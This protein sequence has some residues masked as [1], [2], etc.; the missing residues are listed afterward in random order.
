MLNNSWNLPV[1]ANYEF[2]AAACIF[3]KFILYTVELLMN[4][5]I[6]H[7]AH[8]SSISTNNNWMFVKFVNT[9]PPLYLS[10]SKGVVNIP[11]SLMFLPTSS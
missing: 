8:I 9:S 5:S 6:L 7:Y 10:S 4:Q 3:T 1:I 2:N 11:K